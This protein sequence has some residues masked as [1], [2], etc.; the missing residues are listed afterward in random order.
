[1]LNIFAAAVAWVGM[2]ARMP[3]V[4]GWD[5]FLPDWWADLHSKRKLPS[6]SV[7]HTTY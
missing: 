1:M 5:G 2:A 4:I 7:L 3:M 6:W